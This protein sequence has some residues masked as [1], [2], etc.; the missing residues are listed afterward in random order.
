MSEVRA[1]VE[2]A[3]SFSFSGF[4]ETRGT[5]REGEFVAMAAVRDIDSS[6]IA[7]VFFTLQRQQAARTSGSRVGTDCESNL[8]CRVALAKADL[9]ASA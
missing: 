3:K 4:H 2:R 6:A 5:G 8:V 1:C 7:V 9:F